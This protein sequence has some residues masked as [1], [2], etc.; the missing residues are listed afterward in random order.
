MDSIA[1][2]VAA[3]ATVVVPGTVLATLFVQM[4]GVSTLEHPVFNYST[5][6]H[7]MFNSSEYLKNGPVITR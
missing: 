4:W 1:G 6:F 7:L 2:F 5:E 3:A